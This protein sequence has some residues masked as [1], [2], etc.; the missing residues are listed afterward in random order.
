MQLSSKD[1]RPSS[2][3]KPTKHFRLICWWLVYRV[4][5]E[6]PL[7]RQNEVDACRHSR[8]ALHLWDAGKVLWPREWTKVLAKRQRR[9]E[10]LIEH[11]SVPDGW[12]PPD[13]RDPRRTSHKPIHAYLARLGLTLEEFRARYRYVPMKSKTGGRKP[14]WAL[15]RRVRAWTKER[16]V[17]Q[18]DPTHMAPRAK[19]IHFGSQFRAAKLKP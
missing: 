7:D 4:P 11:G 19:H 18:P 3:D 9:L 17:I 6:K 16:P 13:P 15:I 14:N 2:S 12:C 5:A 1:P 10:W 8:L